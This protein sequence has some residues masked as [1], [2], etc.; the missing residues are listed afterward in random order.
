MSHEPRTPQPT[1]LAPID[2]VPV[3]HAI[4]FEGRLRLALSTAE[5][6]DLLFGGTDEAAVRVV[7]RLL[8]SGHLRATSTGRA[9]VITAQSVVDYLANPLPATA[10]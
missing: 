2:G 6:A 5:V 9:Y 4:A 7:R 10:A 3:V 1:V 8:R